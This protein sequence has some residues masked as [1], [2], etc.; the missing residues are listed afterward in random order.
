MIFKERAIGSYGKT[1]LDDAL[2]FDTAVEYSWAKA[3][4]TK[5]TFSDIFVGK[6]STAAYALH[7]GVGYVF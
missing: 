2:S 6:Y 3:T 4:T 5:K 7:L 1:F